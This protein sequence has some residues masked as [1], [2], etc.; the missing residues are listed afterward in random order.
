[1]KKIKCSECLI[2]KNVTLHVGFFWV[3][4]KLTGI[5]TYRSTL[6]KG[7][8]L[9]L[10]GGR[11]GEWR[12]SSGSRSKGLFRVTQ[13]MVLATLKTIKVK[14]LEQRPLKGGDWAEWTAANAPGR[15][16]GRW[17]NSVLAACNWAGRATKKILN[18]NWIFKLT[19]N[20]KWVGSHQVMHRL[21]LHRKLLTFWRVFNEFFNL[22]KQK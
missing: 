21:L 8:H 13:A 22:L 12:A 1:M 3:A 6:F 18:K 5:W 16:K 14:N 20:K 15:K 9:R 2:S 17:P 4:L 11:L 10:F 19:A 7:M